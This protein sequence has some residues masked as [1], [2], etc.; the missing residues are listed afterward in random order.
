MNTPPSALAGN[1]WGR[2]QGIGD[3]SLDDTADIRASPQNL[4]D[5]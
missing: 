1:P 5:S 4:P 2:T 3:P